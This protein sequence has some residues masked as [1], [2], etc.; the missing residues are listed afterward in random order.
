MQTAREHR[1]PFM[2]QSFYIL[3]GESLRHLLEVDVAF[4]HI[5]ELRRKVGYRYVGVGVV[6]QQPGHLV[7]LLYN[8]GDAEVAQQAEEHHGLE[9]CDEDGYDA[10]LEMEQTAVVLYERLEQ[11]C[12]QACHAEWQQ[13]ILE[14]VDE[15]DGECEYAERY[16]QPHNAVERI[17]TG[18]GHPV[19]L[20]FGCGNLRFEDFSL[21][22]L[23]VG[24]FESEMLFLVESL[25]NE[26]DNECC[27]AE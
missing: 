20:F 5:V 21:G 7:H 6:A 17:W 13:H 19:R 26:S 25:E 9:Q 10:P 18:S 2:E 3:A 27:Q 12:Y 8:G 22:F 1:H 24:L 15:P 16:H 4:E 14:Q 23:D 11:V